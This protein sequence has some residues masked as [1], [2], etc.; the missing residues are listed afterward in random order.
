[1]YVMIENMLPGAW[2]IHFMNTERMNGHHPANGNILLAVLLLAMSIEVGIAQVRDINPWQPVVSGE[3]SDLS[4]RVPGMS[5]WEL[6]LAYLQ[7]YLTRGEDL[8]VAM[9]LP[10]GTTHFKIS[11]SGLL[12]A[13]LQRKF[14]SIKT[15]VGRNPN[16]PSMVLRFDV[17]SR[18]FHGTISSQHGIIY[19]DPQDKGHRY[20]S[21]YKKRGHKA[22]NNH[23]CLPNDTWEKERESQTVLKRQGITRIASPG[24]KLRKYRLAVT[25]SGE[26]TAFHQGTVQGALEAIV[27]TMNRVVGIFER[28]LAITMELV[29]NTDQLIFTNAATDPYTI[30]QTSTFKSQVQAT[31]DAVIG[32]SNYDIGHGFSTGTAGQAEIG[33]VCRRN[34]KA[35][36]VTGL[37]HPAG[38]PFDVDFV[39]HEIGHQFGATHTFNGNA[40]RCDPSSRF[41][42]TAYEPG[43]GTT[44]MGYAGTCRSHDIQSNS[45]DYFHSASLEQMVTFTTTGAGSSCAT[46][47]DTN[48]RPPV[49]DAGNGGF[50][51][52]ILTPFRLEGSATD[53]DGHTLTY[54]WEQFDLGPIGSPNLPLGNAP[55]F[56]SFPPVAEPYRVFPQISDVLNDRQTRGE[57]LPSTNRDLT[58]RLTVRDNHPGG[59][60][61][62]FDT[63]RF[64]ATDEAGPFTITS[65]GDPSE[66]I[67]GGA[68]Q[69]SW[70]VARTDRPPV[71]CREVNIL[72]STDGGLTFDHLLAESTPN[73]GAE[74]VILPTISTTQ[75]RIKIEAADNI[76]FDVSEVDFSIREAE[77]SGFFLAARVGDGIIC[78]PGQETYEVIV[79]QL[80]DFDAPVR[81]TTGELPPGMIVSLSDSI[82][83]PG[84]STQLTLTN[85]SAVQGTY[86][87]VILG[88]S[89]TLSAEATLDL[90]VIENPPELPFS[91]GPSD[92]AVNVDLQPKFLWQGTSENTVSYEMDVATDVNF[93]KIIASDSGLAATSFDPGVLLFDNRQYFWRVRSNT[94]CNVSE[95][96]QA[97]FKTIPLLP[98]QTTSNDIPVPIS[99][100]APAT[101]RSRLVVRRPGTIYD[102][103]VSNLVG[104]HSWLSDLRV[105]LRSPIG[106]EVVLFSG[107]CPRSENFNLKFDDQAPSSYD[108]I[109]CPPIGGET[110]QPF[111]TLANF[112]GENAEGTWTLVVQDMVN[113]DGGQLLSWGLDIFLEEDISAPF[114]PGNLSVTPISSDQ[115][116]VRWEDNSIDEKAFVIERSQNNNAFYEE[117]ARVE[118]D[119][120]SLLDESLSGQGLYYYRVKAV[121][122]GGSSLYSDEVELSIVVGLDPGAKKFS[123]YPNPTDRWL[124]ITGTKA[125]S[126]FEVIITDTSGKRLASYNSRNLDIPQAIDLE[127]LMPGLYLIYIFNEEH[128]VKQKFIK[129]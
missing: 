128:A 125:R 72:L 78:T 82:V 25:A 119:V 92:G 124:H 85:L 6:D 104:E 100:G 69:V 77:N 123:F 39:A 105:T 26:Y 65:Q 3:R 54:C 101:Y 127:G 24:A 88:A 29:D 52:P 70:E 118:A 129:L 93:T 47:S 91:L 62:G 75:A 95:Y 86:S 55:L 67:S 96:A 63:L 58:F 108:H 16:D 110:F 80:K 83:T 89:D 117:I 19:I 10:G 109:S 36:G 34:F 94:V 74:L 33:G 5:Y 61:V 12:S 115:V 98:V 28:E 76:F 68:M 102:V 13:K 106:T 9:P 84:N 73:D 42:E 21:Y 51:I 56:R 32:N 20:K 44:I 37:D 116:D 71:S 111:G 57:I 11:R 46:L 30:A 48:N 79:G 121:N 87:L 107:I 35:Q 114:A 4:S 31:I 23:T 60:G 8:S 49:V 81:L 113:R 27:T 43:S 103:N 14:P 50:F 59:G 112:N 64:R 97:T 38:D 1:M 45:N 17:T 122:E 7:E 126:D 120:D 41:A 2:V 90:G 40:G 66:E 53:P 22:G 99:A 18:G 15:Y